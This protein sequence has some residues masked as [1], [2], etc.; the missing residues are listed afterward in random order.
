MTTP[1]RQAASYVINLYNPLTAQVSFSTASTLSDILL[2]PNFTV[3]PQSEGCF[4]FDY[5]PLKSGDVTG[6]LTLSSSD[7]G[8]YQ[9]DLNLSA[10]PAGPENQ[11]HFRTYLGSTQSQTCRFNNFCK[12]RVEYACKV[13]HSCLHIF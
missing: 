2:P 11:V 9:Y 10:T 5:L 6:R 12:S 1:V 8:F 13:R 4:T 7:L 3:P